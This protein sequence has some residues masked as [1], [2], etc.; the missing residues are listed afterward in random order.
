MSR[1]VAALMG[2]LTAD[3]AGLGL[4]WLYDVNRIAQVTGD[5]PAAFTPINAA[6]FEDTKGYFAHA[7]RKDGQ[8]SQYGET[9]LLVMRSIAENDGFDVASYQTAFSAHFG[10]GG[11]FVGY[12]DRP[13]RGTLENIAAEKTAPSGIDDDQHP[14]ITTLPAIMARYGNDPAMLKAAREVTNVNDVAT[15]YAGIIAQ[16]LAAVIDEISLKDALAQAANSEPL[17]Q[18]ALDSG[19]DPV[20]YGET[21]SR[22]CHLGQGT[23]LSWRILA[24]TTSYQEAVETNIRAGGD[25]AG[26]A[27]IVGALAG[28]AYGMGAIPKDW[29]NK[30]QNAD[31][32]LKTAEML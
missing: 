8:L 17:L 3:A 32:L 14:A 29:I 15:H 22:A 12:I 31:V 25:S 1:Q 10:P 27:M 2:A 23:P 4:H 7:A 9:L 6:N 30:T 24:H 26:R 11:A 21:T 16:T 18:A 5:G 28:A 20:T 13:T 19:A